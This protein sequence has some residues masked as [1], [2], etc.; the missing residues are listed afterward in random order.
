MVLPKKQGS[1]HEVRPSQLCGT[2]AGVL[3]HGTSPSRASFPRLK[4]KGLSRP[5]LATS[6]W[7]FIQDISCVLAVYQT[8]G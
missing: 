3:G 8:V 4:T 5:L 7:F 1:R 2:A 6:I